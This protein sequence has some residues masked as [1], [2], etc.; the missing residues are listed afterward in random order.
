MFM[1]YNLE[2]I[3]ISVIQTPENVIFSLFG[4]LVTL[5]ILVVTCTLRRFL[6]PESS[7]R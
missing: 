3:F 4:D 7:F 2:H 1:Y 6:L 5:T